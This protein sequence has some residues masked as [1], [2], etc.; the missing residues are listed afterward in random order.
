MKKTEYLTELMK[1]DIQLIAIAEKDVRDMEL[2]LGDELKKAEEKCD[3]YEEMYEGDDGLIMSAYIEYER[4]RSPL[5][6]LESVLSDFKRSLIDHYEQLLIEK[7]AYN[8]EIG[9]ALSNSKINVVK[10][11][12]TVEIIKGVLI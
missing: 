9:I 8:N 12:E 1:K 6:E 5:T 11:D 4:I 7:R 3:S 10:M 2:K